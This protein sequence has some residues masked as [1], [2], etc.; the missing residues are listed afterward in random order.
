M[1]A[2]E[3]LNF[4]E[5]QSEMVIN[6]LKNLTPDKITFDVLDDFYSTFQKNVLSFKSPKERNFD[7]CGTGGSGKTRV[8]LSTILAISLSEKFTI[9]KH[10]NKASSGRVGSAD[11]IDKIGYQISNNSTDAINSI[12]NNNLT[13]MFA[14]SF[15][16]YLGKFSEIRKIIKYP[17]IFNFVMP[18][19]NPVENLTA[20]MIGISNENV[21]NCMAKIA[22][23]HNKNIIFVHDK[24]NKLDD[25]SITGETK[26][27]EVC[28]GKMQRYNVNPSDFNIEIVD[29]FEEISGFESSELNADLAINILNHT[30]DNSYIKFLKINK[31]VA[32][33]FFLKCT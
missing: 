3:V 4:Q 5:N 7:V 26:I 23:K 33:K 13:F 14:P 2:S 19:L 29:N 1:I 8:N 16:P 31:A 18:L 15:H 27:I 9:C 21:M 20:Q 24:D 28:R 12:E 6:F 25:V 22:L 17:T 10:S 11:I 32:T 30:A